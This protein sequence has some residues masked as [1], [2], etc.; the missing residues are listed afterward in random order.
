MCYKKVFLC[1]FV[2]EPVDEE[3]RLCFASWRALGQTFKL[4]IKQIWV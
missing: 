3:L 1:E 4:I 2:I